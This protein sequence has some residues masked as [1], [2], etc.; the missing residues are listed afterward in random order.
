MRLVR[1]MLQE[2][3]LAEVVAKR[4]SYNAMRRFLPTGADALGWDEST[5]PALGT[6]RT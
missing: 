1:V 2:A 5:S 6:G 3:G 4:R